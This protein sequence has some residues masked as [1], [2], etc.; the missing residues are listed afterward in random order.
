MTQA[1]ISPSSTSSVD[2]TFEMLYSTY[3]TAILRH[4]Q[5]LVRESEQ[6]EELTQET[7]LRAYKALPKLDT[8]AHLKPWLYRIATNAAY[9]VLR[10]RR[11]IAWQSLEACEL[12]PESGRQDDPQLVYNGSSEA[13]RRALQRMRPRYRQALLLSFLYG[14]SHDSLAQQFHLKQPSNA[15]MLLTRARRSFKHCYETILHEGSLVEEVGAT[16]SFHVPVALEKG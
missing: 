7:F 5:H 14:Y 3:Y 12:V 16:T 10:R 2:E 11:L 1:V 6:A 13:I 15:K 4:I 8:D 9:D